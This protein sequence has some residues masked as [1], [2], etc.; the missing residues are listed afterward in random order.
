VQ[1]FGLLMAFWICQYHSGGDGPPRYC[2]LCID[3]APK[4]IGSS[5]FKY[6]DPNKKIAACHLVTAKILARVIIG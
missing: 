4:G 6:G 5:A 1:L 2:L 3:A